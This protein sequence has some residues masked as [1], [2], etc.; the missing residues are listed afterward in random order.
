[1]ASKQGDK[2]TSPET[3]TPGKN[4][5]GSDGVETPS[6][7]ESPA[8]EIISAFGGLRPL[9]NRLGIAVST[10]QGWKERDSIPAARHEEILQAAAKANI[11]LDVARVRE[12]DQLNNETEDQAAVVSEKETESKEAT[13]KSSSVPAGTSSGSDDSKNGGSVPASGGKPV[14]GKGPE[15]SVKTT[16]IDI[17][18]GKS[19]IKKE[20][21]DKSF[22]QAESPAAVSP[23]RSGGMNSFLFGVGTCALVLAAVVYTRGYWLPMVERLPVIGASEN[24][25]SL[26]NLE[27]RIVGL[28][29]HA[30]TNQGQGVTENRFLSLSEQVRTLKLAQ[31]ELE[32]QLSNL[33]DGGVV[34]TTANVDRGLMDSLRKELAETGS[35]L[36]KLEQSGGQGNSGSVAS[37]DPAQASRLEALQSEVASLSARFDNLGTGQTTRPGP[38][39]NDVYLALAVL[40][41]RDALRGS[42]PFIRELDL[43]RAVSSENATLQDLVAPLS[44]FASEGL[45]SMTELRADFPAAARSALSADKVAGGQTWVDKALGRI[46]NVISIRP[47]DVLDGQ[48]TASVLARAENYLLE[49]DLTGAV[50]ELEGLTSAARSGMET[51]LLQAG[52]RLEG[53]RVSGKLAL[54]LIGVTEQGSGTGGVQ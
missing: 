46:S 34:V 13:V 20:E 41:L 43:V 32:R 38:A 7:G 25:I 47:V 52:H 19:D 8:Q 6:S 40:Q 51:W 27:E 23:R 16:K 29:Q 21:S 37:F 28:E 9:A 33:T 36:K 50:R 3:K 12:S 45:P 11:K 44:S 2:P 48:G 10:V 1:M 54:L 30:L 53:E 39:T 26:E 5:K 18:D 24:Q 42:G 31:S 17:S 35:R 49:G 22:S 4:P 15:V 14:S